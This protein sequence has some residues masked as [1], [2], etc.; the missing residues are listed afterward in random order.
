MYVGDVPYVGTSIDSN[1]QN[2][3]QPIRLNSK[4]VLTI[5]K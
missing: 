1:Y 5:I 3:L 4:L 2:H